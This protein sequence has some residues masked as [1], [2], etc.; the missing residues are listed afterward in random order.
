M[1]LTNEYCYVDKNKTAS[2]Y[3]N[4]RLKDLNNGNFYFKHHQVPSA[5]VIENKDI[6]KFGTVRNPW[7]WYVSLWSYA[8]KKKEMVG[9]YNNLTKN[10]IVSGYGKVDNPFRAF[11]EK[12]CS[13][14]LLNM[15]T[16]TQQ[17]YEDF[18]SVE[19]FR[20][21]LRI[22][23][24]DKYAAVVD[25]PRFQ[26]GLHKHSGLWTMQMIKFYFIHN[27][28]E[29][30]GLKTQE[31]LTRLLKNNC[32]IDDFINVDNIDINLSNFF[33]KYGFHSDQE[34]SSGAKLNVSSERALF[35]DKMSFELV[36]KRE[37]IMMD[38]LAEFWRIDF[39]ISE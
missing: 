31:C 24:D 18:L 7:D 2:V 39:L 27:D 13:F 11:F 3:V 21:W 5:E 28:F 26:S 17:L 25:F 12:Q 23:L 38:W 22:V 16:D 6:I 1:F 37:K 10:R 19:N 20:Q 4:N 9:I 35:Y 33:K 32:Y 29:R 8:C 15:R 14:Y 34:F 30:N 36:Y